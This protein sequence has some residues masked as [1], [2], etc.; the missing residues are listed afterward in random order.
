MKVAI[1]CGSSMGSSEDIVARVKDLGKFL[2]QNGIDL[3]YG[4]GKVGLMGVIAD[5]F[6][7]YGA[8]V[9]GVIPQ[10]LQEKELAHT[11]VTELT[12]VEDMHERKAKMADMADAFITLPG[13]AGTLEEIIEVWVWAQLGYHGKPCAFYNINNFYDELFEMFENMSNTGFLKE[14]Y[15]NMLINTEDKIEL[16]E[17]IKNYTAPKQ[18]WD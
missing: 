5:T 11:G 8:K 17:K 15:I 16:L 7:E 9:Y 10:K 13:G 14:D 1:Y 3:V 6:L 4:G 12:I 18:K 2:A